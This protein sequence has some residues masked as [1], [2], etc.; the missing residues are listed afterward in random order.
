MSAGQSACR[1]NGRENIM[2]EKQIRDNWFS[3]LEKEECIS[4]TIEW[5]F[6]MQDLI[7]IGTIHKKGYFRDKIEDLLED[8]NFHQECSLLSDGKYDE[9]MD[10]VFAEYLPKK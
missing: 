3:A 9:Y 6:Y 4:V 10:L 7:V 8:C 5:A 2:T 1:E